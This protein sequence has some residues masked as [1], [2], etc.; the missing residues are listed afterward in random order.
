M[1]FKAAVIVAASMAVFAFALPSGPEDPC[2]V[3]CCERAN[4]IS[5]PHVCQPHN[6]GVSGNQVVDA[7][8]E[9]AQQIAPLVGVDL[10]S[11]TGQV[12]LTC[13]LLAGSGA[14]CKIKPVCCTTNFPGEFH[15]LVVQVT[16][17]R[18][19]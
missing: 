13:G 7:Y 4:S 3:Q 19:F 16:P 14:A 9:I 1:F 15:R 5:P 18:L 11:Q 17:R 8:S 2:V 12:G 6:H 10:S